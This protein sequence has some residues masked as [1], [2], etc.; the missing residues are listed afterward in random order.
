VSFSYERERQILFDVSFTIPA[1]HRVAVVDTPARANPRSRACCIVSTMHPP[2]SIV[3]NGQDVR[4]LKQASLRAR[5]ASCRRT[6][7]LFNDSILYNIRYGRPE[8]GDAEVIE[9]AR[10]AISTTSSNL[11]EEN[12]K[13]TVGRAAA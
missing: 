12:T 2:V 5:S 11:C 8:A 3:I 1:G 6:R 4:E 10:A 9:A 13:P 7:C